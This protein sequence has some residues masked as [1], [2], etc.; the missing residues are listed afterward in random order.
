MC[1]KN[2]Q[3]I[4]SHCGDQP[5]FQ[6]GNLKLSHTKSGSVDNSEDEGGLVKRGEGCWNYYRWK[7]ANFIYSELITN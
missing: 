7:I 5:P 1:H 2:L 4:L 6:K 3:P